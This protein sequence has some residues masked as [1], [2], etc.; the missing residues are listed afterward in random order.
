MKPDSVLVKTVY[1]RGHAD[2]YALR[3]LVD[4]TR[5][6]IYLYQT[7]S[8]IMAPTKQGSITDI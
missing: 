8:W 5:S 4:E 1:Y 6:R 3:I 2:G 7:I